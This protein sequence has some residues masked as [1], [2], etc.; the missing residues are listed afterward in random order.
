M[1]CGMVVMTITYRSAA[2]K[3][4]TNLGYSNANAVPTWL[5]E[6]WL[7]S[8]APAKEPD[9]EP[10][11]EPNS[12]LTWEPGCEPDCEPDWERTWVPA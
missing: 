1:C 9:S 7:A 5:R 12:M 8:L 11:W 6:I 2:L 3:A 10:A 4:I